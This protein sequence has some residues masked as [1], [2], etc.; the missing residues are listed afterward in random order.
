MRHLILTGIACAGFV[1][2][3]ASQRAHQVEMGVLVSYTRF[4]RRFGFEN[5]FGGGGRIGFFLT[6]L[7]SLEIDGSYLQP[8][9]TSGT[10]TSEL[11]PGGVSVALNFGGDK[12]IFYLL[13]GYSHYAFFR[14]APGRFSDDGIHGAIG[15]RIFIEP[16][17]AFRAEVR[18][19]Y[20][21]QSKAPAAT[22]EWAGH[23]TASIG[24]DFFFG[25]R[26][27]TD[28]DHDLVA[29]RQDAC[30]D[31]P[32]NAA[33][34]VRGCPTD[35]D[36]DGVVNGLDACPNSPSGAH[37][38]A[39]GCP[40]DDDKDGVPDGV[41][42]CPNTSGG[43]AVDS[44][45]C[46]S[47]SDAD[48]VPDGVDQCPNTEFGMPVDT[49]GCPLDT[50]KDRVPDGLDRCPNTPPNTEV[51][52]TGCTTKR[53]TDGDG[54]DDADDRCPATATGS[55]VDASGCPILF[56]PGRTALILRGVTFETGS[57]NLR[58]ESFTI[59]DQ[60]AG[61]LIANPD[62]RIEIGGHTDN[63]GSAATNIRL[64][65]QRANAVM[66]YLAGKGVSQF[67]M[68]ARGYGSTRPVAPNTTAA[69]RAQNR[70]VELRRLN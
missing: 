34:D 29:D 26:P 51:D 33:V 12:N 19:V 30:P 60:V 17:V 13:G 39:R 46:P 22:G 55:R 65:Q 4:D 57:S 64:S 49:V 24:V 11:V 48:R 52:A 62:V 3:A 32:A 40:T 42:Q 68:A 54:V 25:G 61:S 38:D 2:P 6:D 5:Q 16:G 10:G 15:D 31:T 1:L 41:D 18:G 66:Q 35:S 14:T 45:G 69:G 21:P 43:A 20:I 27:A 28:T 50:D 63:T 67:H 36:R 44:R 58:P 9:S 7:L 70:R 8:S 37:I 47:D 23:V 56:A 53:D 59:L